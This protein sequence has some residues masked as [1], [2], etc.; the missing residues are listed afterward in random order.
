M[1]PLLCR[2]GE[3]LVSLLSA[4]ECGSFVVIDDYA[5]QKWQH[6][7]ER[8]RKRGVVLQVAVGKGLVNEV[9]AGPLAPPPRRP[10][11]IYIHRRYRH[12]DG[13]PSLVTRKRNVQQPGDLPS[14]LPPGE[15]YCISLPCSSPAPVS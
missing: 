6:P 13:P 12:V 4:L 14:T 9:S 11:V 10:P 1:T 8:A 7:T 3:T 2:V 15:G 5:V